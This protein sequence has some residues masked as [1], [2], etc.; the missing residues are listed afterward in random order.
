M[1]LFDGER[2]FSFRRL[3]I[4]CGAALLAPGDAAPELPSEGDK[5]S[6]LAPRI[7]SDSER[8]SGGTPSSRPSAAGEAA[9]DESSCTVD[10]VLC[11]GTPCRGESAQRG[12]AVIFGRCATSPPPQ[13]ASAALS[14]G[15]QRASERLRSPPRTWRPGD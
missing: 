13:Y 7:W 1:R 9:G 11:A 4:R 15:A 14:P 8:L 10:I 3:I 12:D 6:A 2:R 5:S